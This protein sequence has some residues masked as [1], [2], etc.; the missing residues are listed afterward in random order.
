MFHHQSRDAA[1]SG[2][3][4]HLEAFR[5][6]DATTA[7]SL[8][9]KAWRADCLIKFSLCSTAGHRCATR[10]RENKSSDASPSPPVRQ[11]TPQATPPTPPWPTNRAARVATQHGCQSVFPVEPFHLRPAR[12]VCDRRAQHIGARG[13]QHTV[14]HSISLERGRVGGACVSVWPW[15]KQVDDGRGGRRANSTSSIGL[16]KSRGPSTG[17]AASCAMT[18]CNIRALTLYHPKSASQAHTTTIAWW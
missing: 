8:S 1:S 15:S 12:L 7:A 3:R 17:R 13:P 16:L 11:M 4:R 6:R 14:S 10:G 18:Q 5:T 9:V 2:G